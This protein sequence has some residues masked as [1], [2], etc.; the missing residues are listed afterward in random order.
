MELSR[1]LPI[2][3][4]VAITATTGASA[5][6]TSRRPGF[7]DERC[8]LGYAD[9]TNYSSSAADLCR[10]SGVEGR[11]AAVLGSKCYL[12]FEIPTP[13]QLPLKEKIRTHEMAAG[14]MM[15]KDHLVVT[16]CIIAVTIGMLVGRL[17]V[18]VCDWR[19]M[20]ATNNRNAAAARG[21]CRAPFAAMLA[22]LVLAR[23][24]GAVAYGFT[25]HY[26]P[27]ELDHF[28][29]TPASSTVFNQRYLINDSFW[30]R[31]HV[32]DGQVSGPI[33]VYT[34]NESPV[35]FF[36]PSTGFMFDIAPKFGA[37]LVF[38]EHRFYGESLPFGNH[39]YD[40]T[41]K[42][43]YLTSTQALADYAIL[44]SSLKQN[45][46]A[47]DS[48]VVVFGGSYGGMLA[49][50]FR[51][52]YP[53][54]AI[55]ALA[56]SAPILMFDHITPWTSFYDAL[57][58][59]YKS[60]SLNCFSVIKAV[61]AVLYERG[62]NKTGLLELSKTFRACQTVQ[63]VDFFGRWL[64]DAFKFTTLFD[65]P[66]PVNFVKNLPAY[67]VKE[68]CKIIDGFSGGAD[69]VQKAFAAAS[70]YYNY[71]GT[72]HCFNIEKAGDPL[73]P[74]F[75]WQACTEMILPMTSSKYSIFPPS[76]FSYDNRS[77]DCLRTFK[78]QPRPHWVTTEY[79]GN[80]IEHVLK[81][82]GSNIIFSNRTRDPLSRGGVLKNISSSIIALVAEKGAHHFDL[83]GATK[84]DPEWVVEQRRQEVE[85]IQGWLKQYY[86]D[87]A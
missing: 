41:E 75:Q 82:F 45:L 35:D 86:D 23:P 25:T 44:I 12:R 24:E 66:V 18:R 81:R 72:E 48:P 62:S 26:F 10:I 59:D 49:A 36:I 60:E 46:S 83:R 3:L 78:V 51:L 8:F 20:K 37:L 76:E 1:F 42:L 71:T 14:R 32:G 11:V 61:W 87:T 39:S 69:V 16:L 7:S 68:M 43:G 13:P 65:Y 53:H 85:I 22:L 54:V 57:L 5:D 30:T 56:S 38:I 6:R 67:P 40:S 4:L 74:I 17:I 34:G 29:F 58:E 79:G 52:K 55:G 70:L 73:G 64:E 27:Q 80:K 2:L 47:V 33:F 31:S 50:W 9:G 63:S 21:C 84:H 19:T 28:S 77:A 15:M